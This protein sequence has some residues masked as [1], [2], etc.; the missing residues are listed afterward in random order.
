MMAYQGVE[1]NLTVMICYSRVDWQTTIVLTG[2]LLSLYVLYR[3]LLT[4][5]EIWQ[6]RQIWKTLK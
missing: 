1:A 5:I 3:L 2:T 4:T 6:K